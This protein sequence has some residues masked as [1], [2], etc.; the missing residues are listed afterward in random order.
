[1]VIP[2]EAMAMGM[3]DVWGTVRRNP[4]VADAN[5]GSTDHDR[6]VSLLAALELVN[7]S[8]TS[9]WLIHQFILLNS[10][11]DT[12]WVREFTRE[13]IDQSIGWLSECAID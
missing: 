12:L 10:L 5:N 11:N 6:I 8:E 9:G 7:V 13:L 4:E 2:T 3:I 1:M